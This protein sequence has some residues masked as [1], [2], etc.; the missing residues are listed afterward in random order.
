M[1]TNQYQEIEYTETSNELK[2]M[3]TLGDPQTTERISG[4]RQIKVKDSKQY[5]VDDDDGDTERRHFS[6]LPGN[7]AYASA[8]KASLKSGEERPSYL[9]ENSEFGL[10][11]RNKAIECEEEKKSAQNLD[12]SQVSGPG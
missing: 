11:I 3:E 2:Q 12:D 1:A 7:Q 10:K 8:A 5:E 4:E 6:S 9:L